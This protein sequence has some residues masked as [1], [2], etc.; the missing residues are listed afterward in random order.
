MEQF[1]LPRTGI[2]VNFPKA[3]IIRPSGDIASRGVI[4][5]VEIIAPLRSAQDD[6]LAAALGV[7]RREVEVQ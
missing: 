3:H 7:I 5:E 6:S 4:P 2:V 1:T